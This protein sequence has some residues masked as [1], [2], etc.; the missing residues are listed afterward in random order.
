MWANQTFEFFNDGSVQRDFLM[1]VYGV[2]RRDLG[3]TVA[4]NS[5]LEHNI[6]LYL[7]SI[8]KKRYSL[9]R[10]FYARGFGIT[11]SQSVKPGGDFISRF[12]SSYWERGLDMLLSLLSNMFPVPAI[13]KGERIPILLD[14]PY[15]MVFPF[16]FGHQC[17]NR[18]IHR[19]C[20]VNLKFGRAAGSSFP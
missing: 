18:L 2:L 8:S 6:N 16:R 19:I 10:N 11:V 7:G 20:S 4:Q 17:D 13:L 14:S 5:G 12:W 1:E 15:R 3:V 9:F